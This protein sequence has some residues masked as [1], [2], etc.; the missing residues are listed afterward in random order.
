MCEET[1][2]LKGIPDATVL[3]G[4]IFRYPV[5]VFAFQGTITQ[6]K[7]M[8]LNA[9]LGIILQQMSIHF[10]F[11]INSIKVSLRDAL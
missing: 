11:K 10:I 9:L 3:V 7:V 8:L 2:V 6:Y 1:K 4:K 5:P